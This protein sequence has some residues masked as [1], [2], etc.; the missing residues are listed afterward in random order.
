[1]AGIEEAEA[2]LSEI[3]LLTSMFPSQDEFDVKDHL[4][5]AE[6]REYVEGRTDC[7]PS[8]RPEFVIQQKIDTQDLKAVTIAIS[9]T[10][11]VDYPNVL[12]DISVRCSELS[13]AQQTRLH[14]DMNAYLKENC[15]GEVCLLSAVEWV[16]DNAHVYIAKNLAANSLKKVASAA[17]PVEVFTRLWI[18]SH[19]IYN[20]V[21]RKNILEWSSDLGLSGF[22][23]PGKP[24]IVCVEGPQAS[25]EEFW[26]RVKVLTWKRIMIRH[27]EDFPLDGQPG[28]EEE[29]VTSLRRFPGFEEA[30]FDPHGN[31]GN[32]MDLGQLYQFLNDKGCGDVFQLYFG[33]EGR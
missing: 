9:C 16:K 7:P 1:M 8:S 28:T 27:R 14:A 15:C 11:A 32:H 10:Y 12:P 31:R 5:I 33:I 22:C 24:G 6:L 20:K 4:A 21:K 17:Q 18:Y 26:A 19:H 25:C 23:M 29:T 2:Q 30:M 3:E 13:R